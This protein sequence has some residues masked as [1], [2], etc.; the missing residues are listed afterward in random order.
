MVKSL[1]GGG[2]ILVV[3]TKAGMVYGIDPD[4]K[5]NVLWQTKIGEGG[6]QGGVIWGSSSDDKAAYFSISDWNPGKAEAG[7]GVAAVEI[8]TGR[9][10]W[11][12]PAPKPACLAA[13][14][15]SAAQPGAT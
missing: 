5:G 3:G 12:T 4:N 11:S 15:C 9:K 13:K 14:G 10:I 7:G 2:R 8:A 6:G 1:G